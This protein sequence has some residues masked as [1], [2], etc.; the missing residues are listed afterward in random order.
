MTPPR[1]NLKKS[2]RFRN[3]IFLSGPPPDP[4]IEGEKTK[5]FFTEGEKT[6]IPLIEG[7]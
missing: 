7:E 4:L 1:S 6:K 2:R 3:R 5:F